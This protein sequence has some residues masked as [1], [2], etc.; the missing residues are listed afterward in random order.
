[1]IKL[2]SGSKLLKLKRCHDSDYV[3]IAETDEEYQRLK[4]QRPSVLDED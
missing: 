2:L 1:M 3:I 4:R